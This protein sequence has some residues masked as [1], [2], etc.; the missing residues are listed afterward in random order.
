M[1]NCQH[2]IEN[3]V[4]T[5]V[6]GCHTSNVVFALSAVMY[7]K[8]FTPEYHKT[9]EYAK[10]MAWQ[11]SSQRPVGK[12]RFPEKHEPSWDECLAF[13]DAVRAHG[14]K[15]SADEVEERISRVLRGEDVSFEDLDAVR[16]FYARFGEMMLSR[17]N[18]R[19]GGCF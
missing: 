1:L 11:M 12:M 4:A 2:P 18:S 16:A 3:T 8:E 7:N 5:M 14:N 13:A 17:A 10:E 6:L 9:L 15:L 19:H